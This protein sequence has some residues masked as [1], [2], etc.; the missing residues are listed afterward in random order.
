M[1]NRRNKNAILSW[2]DIGPSA[3]LRSFETCCASYNSVWLVLMCAHRLCWH[4]TKIQYETDRVGNIVTTG[5]FFSASD[6]IE[7]IY[8]F[9]QTIP[10]CY[11]KAI[12]FFKKR[13]ND[14]MINGTVQ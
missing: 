5:W 4:S 8:S 11:R 1:V 12:L 3:M 2:Y 6:S 13:V 7:Q 14:G 10:L 9:E